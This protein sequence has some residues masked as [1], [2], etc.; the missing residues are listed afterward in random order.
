MIVGAFALLFAEIRIGV[1]LT[2]HTAM[3]TSSSVL[4]YQ[5][6]GKSLYRISG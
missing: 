4:L 2:L 5:V 3:F 1:R 6:R